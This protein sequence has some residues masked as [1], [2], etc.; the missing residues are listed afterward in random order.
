MV[1]LPYLTLSQK[2]YRVAVILASRSHLLSRCEHP[3]GRAKRFGKARMFLKSRDVRRSAFKRWGNC[4]PT[5]TSPSWRIVATVA[6]WPGLILPNSS[7]IH[8][9]LWILTHGCEQRDVSLP[10]HDFKMWMWHFH[11]PFPTL[12]FKGSATP[13]GQSHK[14]GPLNQIVEEVTCQPWT[15][16]LDCY[17]KKKLI[18]IMLSQWNVGISWL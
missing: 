13:D 4:L 17:Q 16:S 1:K 2:T 6:A 12:T 14:T 11:L 10:D 9:G 18:S 15:S 7:R 3:L 8:A 5:T